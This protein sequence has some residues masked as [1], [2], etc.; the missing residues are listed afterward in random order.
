MSKL[1]DLK[2]MV[3]KE[4]DG[5][6]FKAYVDD[7][8]EDM[9]IEEI[10][11]YDSKYDEPWGTEQ[12]NNYLHVYPVEWN[13]EKVEESSKPQRMTNQKLM[14]WLA[15]G[16][17]MIK[18]SIGSVGTYFSVWDESLD[19]PCSDEFKVRKWDSTEWIEPTVDLLEEPYTLVDML[20]PN[21]HNA[22][23]NMYAERI[24]DSCQ[25][26]DTKRDHVKADDIVCNLL[27]ELGFNK[28]V[29]AYEDVD[30]LYA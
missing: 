1:K 11:S 14:E 8:S 25:S 20:E 10:V 9:A 2:E 5:T 30:K 3:I 4:W 16:N 19:K 12:C 17:G 29:E 28:V 13:K 7:G 21:T 6:P 26:G 23:D 18:N 27:E 22:L 15:K 24:Q